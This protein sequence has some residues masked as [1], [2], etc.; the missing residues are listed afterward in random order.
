MSDSLPNLPKSLNLLEKFFNLLIINDNRK[1]LWKPQAVLKR[2]LEL[3]QKNHSQFTE[4]CHQNSEQEIVKFWWKLVID[5]TQNWEDWEPSNRK[6]LAL[7]HL[8]AY[9][10]NSCYWAVKQICELQIKNDW[11]DYFDIAKAFV[12]QS[13]K[14]ESAIR[15]Y[16]PDR[17]AN[18]NTF[19]QQILI[20]QIR[21][22]AKVNKC[23]PWR[24]L[25]I[26]SPDKLREALQA[27]GYKEPEISVYLF[28]RKY[29]KQVYQLN[30]IHNPTRTKGERWT[31]PVLK[32]FQE[33]VNLYNAEKQ[34]PSAP[35]EVRSFSGVVTSE[36]VKDWM[37]I[38]IRVLQAH[39]K[40]TE[41]SWEAIQDSSL[42]VT[43]EQLAKLNLPA[44][45]QLSEVEKEPS[46]SLQKDAELRQELIKINT[47]IEQLIQQKKLPENRQYFCLLYYGFD[48]TQ[49]QIAYL[50]GIHQTNIMRF[51]NKYY[52]NP[53]I[54]KIVPLTHPPNWIQ[55]YIQQW[56]LKNYTTPVHTDLIQA[57]LIKSLT[58]LAPELQNILVLIYGQK[59]HKNQVACQLG[60]TE[61]FVTKSLDTVRAHLANDL[62]KNLEI[63]RKV[64]LE[65]WLKKFYQKEIETILHKACL[66]LL[67]KQSNSSLNQ[68]YPKLALK[69]LG[70]GTDQMREQLMDAVVI[71]LQE[72]LDVSIIRESELTK[73]SKVIQAWLESA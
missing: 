18:L 24:L 36:Q 73:V 69:Q 5:D 10:Q 42:N 54:Q 6:Q 38:C 21:S 45:P 14:L 31:E 9:L 70:L 17:G 68:S 1:L 34:L 13:E 39:P 33:I 58:G 30:H 7:Q 20:S 26:A 55:P 8:A 72:N 19:F 35:H 15:K 41:V 61:E 63:W 40:I 57:S 4:L 29:F 32:D 49:Q 12:Y 16:N 71:W 50:S 22:E 47:R 62:F 48:F 65:L 53:L 2:N 60:L 25:C 23:S 59:I 28:I 66:D 11:Y 44:Q 43:R 27:A 64:Y 52:F 3:Y 46:I 37:N 51:I 56:L 67:F